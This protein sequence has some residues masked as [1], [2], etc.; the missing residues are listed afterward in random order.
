M[1]HMM[2][3]HALTGVGMQP[4]RRLTPV[5]QRE[6]AM[7]SDY[8]LLT[9]M[10]RRFESTPPPTRRVALV[11]PLKRDESSGVDVVKKREARC[12]VDPLLQRLEEQAKTNQRTRHEPSGYQYGNNNNNNA[13]DSNEDNAADVAVK[14]VGSQKLSARASSQLRTVKELRY[15]VPPVTPERKPGIANPVNAAVQATV[16]MYGTTLARYRRLVGMVAC[17]CVISVKRSAAQQ[18]VHLRLCERSARKIQFR[19]R[20]FLRGRARARSAKALQRVWRGHVARLVCTKMMAAHKAK[21]EQ[22]AQRRRV[23]ACRCI[24]RCMRKHLDRQKKIRR[25]RLAVK[26]WIHERRQVKAEFLRTDMSSIDTIPIGLEVDLPVNPPSHFPRVARVLES[27]GDAF[28]HDDILYE[29][30]KE[31]EET[32]G[33]VAKETIDD[34]NQNTSVDLRD[35]VNLCAEK[36]EIQFCQYEHCMSST[37]IAATDPMRALVGT[38]ALSAKMDCL[39]KKTD[40]ATMI[41][42]EFPDEQLDL[43]DVVVATSRFDYHQDRSLNSLDVVEEKVTH[44]S[45]D[46]L[47][48]LIA[49]V[50]IHVDLHHADRT[51]E[52]RL[53]F[54]ILH[55]HY[56][57]SRER[58]NAAALKLQSLFRKLNALKL[59]ERIRERAIQSLEAELEAHLLSTQP[60]DCQITPWGSS[61][62]TREQVQPSYSSHEPFGH[63]YL[64]A[65]NGQIPPGVD[66]DRESGDRQALWTWSWKTEKWASLLMQKAAR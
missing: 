35:H 56:K 60:I 33:D 43:V 63:P 61:L 8:A 28:S 51:H 49:N 10:G 19:V 48:R 12:F 65:Q 15:A 23:L 36:T 39:D 34:E 26:V 6:H 9:S 47:P 41:P 29:Q 37:H 40:E 16:D 55:E 42:S 20:C 30:A 2:D 22:L 58:K 18:V 5:S 25:V 7:G 14:S 44:T 24:E 59:V 45:S 53:V 13:E 21:L 64:P 31:V 27:H 4:P 54:N 66:I 50:P 1:K 17:K 52:W 62:A 57:Q 32:I 38:I 11:K 46:I 3:R